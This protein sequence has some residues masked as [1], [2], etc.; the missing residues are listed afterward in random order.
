MQD[1]LPPAAAKATKYYDHHAFAWE[2]IGTSQKKY[3]Q[4][5][6]LNYSR[7]VAARSRLLTKRIASEKNSFVQLLPQVKAKANDNKVEVVPPIIIKTAK[8]CVIELPQSINASALSLVLKSLG[9]S[10]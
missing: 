1:N 6:N 4:Q 2:D 9:A 8:G 10:L 5:H 7:F 3:C